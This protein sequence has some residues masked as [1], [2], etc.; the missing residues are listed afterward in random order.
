MSHDRRPRD[1]RFAAVLPCD[2]SNRGL[3]IFQDL[4]PNILIY[5]IRWTGLPDA[6]R[7]NLQY[8]FDNGSTWK[9]VSDNIA[10]TSYNWDIPA[11]TKNQTKCRIKVTAYDVQGQQTD[12]DTSDGPFT[13]EVIRVVSPNGGE[14]WLSGE[15]RPVE[16]AATTR[17]TVDKIQVFYTTNGGVSWRAAGEVTGGETSLKWV[18]PDVLKLKEKCKVKVV[19]KDA[20]RK[21]LGSDMSDQT[22]TIQP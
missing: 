18:I 17:N 15:T 1:I 6:T 11:L 12:S 21:T 10:E 8:S 4:T 9:F 3:L 16:W 2:N 20:E 22:F 13:I 14:E 5:E 7:Y 19:L